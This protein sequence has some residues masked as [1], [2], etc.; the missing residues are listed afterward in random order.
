MAK[1]TVEF[2]VAIDLSD[3]GIDDNCFNAL[4]ELPNLQML[5]LRNTQITAGAAEKFAAKFK[6]CLVVIG[7]GIDD[8]YLNEDYWDEQ[9]CVSQFALNR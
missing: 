8:C 6:N 3:C 4:A 7:D 1:K 9:A 2:L 5:L